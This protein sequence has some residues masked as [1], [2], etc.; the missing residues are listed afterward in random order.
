MPRWSL[1]AITNARATPAIGFSTTCCNDVSHLPRIR[2]TSSFPADTSPSISVLR[3]SVPTSTTSP[4]VGVPVETAGRTPVTRSTSSRRSFTTRTTPAWSPP[5]TNNG[6]AL[7][8]AASVNPPSTG[9][10]E[11]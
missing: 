4:D 9:A 6:A 10:N 3:P 1:P 8:F 11:T 5:L 2:S 7:P